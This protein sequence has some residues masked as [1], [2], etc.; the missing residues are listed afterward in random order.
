MGCL[1]SIY[2]IL[3][4]NWSIIYYWNGHGDVYTSVGIRLNECFW[5]TI[6]DCTY[7]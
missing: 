2:K 6:V 7:K 1:K 3:K 4:F 5:S